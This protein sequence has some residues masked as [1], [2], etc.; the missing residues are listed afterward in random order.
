MG[1]EIFLRIDWLKA[2]LCIE[3]PPGRG[4][5]ILLK[6]DWLKAQLSF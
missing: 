4:F 5:E 1:L 6:I 3:G 2:Q